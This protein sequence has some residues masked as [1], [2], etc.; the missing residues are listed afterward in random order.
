MNEK[1]VGLLMAFSPALS[2]GMMYAFKY[3]YTTIPYHWADIGITV[4]SFAPATLLG[5]SFSSETTLG[6]SL[7]PVLAAVI[8]YNGLS[9]IKNLWSDYLTPPELIFASSLL[10][11]FA[12]FAFPKGKQKGAVTSAVISVITILLILSSLTTIPQCSR[13]IPSTLEPKFLAR[14]YSNSGYI[15]VVDHKSEYGMIRLLRSDHS[16]IGGIYADEEYY[17]NCIY[18][19]FYFLSFV[20]DIERPAKPS[21]RAVNIGLGVGIAANQLMKRNV[22]VDIVELDPAV[23]RFASDYFDL[24]EASSVHIMDGRK[25][26]EDS[27]AGQYDFV[28]HDVFANGILP[29]SLFSV[30]AMTHVKRVLITNGILAL[31]RLLIDDSELIIQELCWKSGF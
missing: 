29:G 22:S 30:E 14:E 9:F 31:V 13:A 18:G 4:L 20:P 26:L 27:P 8:H 17:G 11:I 21:L 16:I 15:S 25:F 7:L 28:L 6:R 1:A 5:G 2:L 24:Q 12:S 3:I 19:S 10:W 23:A